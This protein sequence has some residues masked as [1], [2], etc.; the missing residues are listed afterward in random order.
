MPSTQQI[1][2]VDMAH[3][4]HVN[5]KFQTRTRTRTP[6]HD[7]LFMLTAN[8]SDYTSGSRH[9]PFPAFRRYSNGSA[10]GL[11]AVILPN[12]SFEVFI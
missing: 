7:S 10:H 2:F 11:T 1:N 3:I 5:L 12:N 8:N 6:D 9:V 4:H